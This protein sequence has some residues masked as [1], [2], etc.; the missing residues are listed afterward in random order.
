LKKKGKYEEAL[1]LLE[2]GDSLKPIYNHELFPHLQE[3]R[4]AVASQK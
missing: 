1:K 3:A 2:K 4:K